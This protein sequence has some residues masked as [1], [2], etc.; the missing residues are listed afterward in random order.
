MRWLV[1]LFLS[2]SINS[3]AQVEIKKETALYYLEVEDKYRLELV[4]DTLQTELIY[5]LK[6]ESTLKSEIINSYQSREEL[7]E[8]MIVTL[9]EEVTLNRKEVKRIQKN[10]LK[11][12]LEDEAIIVLIILI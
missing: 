11:E 3:I 12:K 8:E 5:G 10:R 1:I 9:K 4:K 7:Y 6:Q 2:M